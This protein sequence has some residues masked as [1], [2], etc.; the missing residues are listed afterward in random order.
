MSDYDGICKGHTGSN[1]KNNGISAIGECAVINPIGCSR[2]QLCFLYFRLIEFEI[3]VD[4]QNKFSEV[5]FLIISNC[6]YRHLIPKHLHNH[7]IF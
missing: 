6:Y 4:G 3:Q 5:L 7:C 1:F 2:T